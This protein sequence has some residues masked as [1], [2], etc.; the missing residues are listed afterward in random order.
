MT[1][2]FVPNFAVSNAQYIYSAADISEQISVAGA[3]ASGT[4]N[5]K[6]MMNGAITLG[7]YDGSNIEITELV[8]EENIKIFGLRA[9]EVDALRA[10]GSYYA[11]DMYN[12]DRAR[13]G[14]IIDQLTD[15][16][17]ARLSGNFE[18]VRDALMVNNDQ[19]LVLKD[20]YSYVQ[21]W[22]ELTALYPNQQRWDR[23]SVHNT[24]ESGFFSSDRTIREYARDIWHV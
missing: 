12:A 23:I 18:S 4:S 15:G 19:D 8:G 11:W 2:A 6:L 14:R 7:T 13:L 20:F 21:A 5:M 17:F 3:E 16:T 22:E 10:S 24:A 1:V 9:H